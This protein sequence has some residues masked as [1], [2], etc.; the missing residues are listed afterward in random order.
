MINY[1]YC[2][3]W[4]NINRFFSQKYT[5]KDI[6][7]TKE[8]YSHDVQTKTLHKQRKNKHSNVSRGTFVN[9]FLVKH[10]KPIANKHKL[11]YTKA[12]NTQYNIY[13]FK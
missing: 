6:F 13:E 10:K 3:T 1:L 9:I 5:L 12:L 7:T 11:M 8:K 4:N 2:F